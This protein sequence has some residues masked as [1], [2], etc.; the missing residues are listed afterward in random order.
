VLLLGGTV[1][2]ARKVRS[3]RERGVIAPVRRAL[4]LALKYH[5]MRLL[6]LPE[7]LRIRAMD[8]EFD[9]PAQ[10]TAKTT[11][12]SEPAGRRRLPPGGD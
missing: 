9:N 6:R 11:R 4:G 3:K 12:R 10:A 2:A 7:H 1:V 8:E 5:L